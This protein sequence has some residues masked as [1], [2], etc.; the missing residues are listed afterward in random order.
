MRP[1]ALTASAEQLARRG[2]RLTR[3]GSGTRVL[4]GSPRRRQR[5]TL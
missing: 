5:G 3:Y 2:G 1:V 4:I